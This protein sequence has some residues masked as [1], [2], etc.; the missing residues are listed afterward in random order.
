[1]ALFSI[2]HEHNHHI[3]D[4][5]QVQFMWSRLMAK[6]DALNASQAALKLSLDALKTAVDALKAKAVDGDP[7]APVDAL[8]AASDEMKAQADALTDEV[9]VILNPP[10]PPAA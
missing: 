5:E 7:Q 1:M 10:A 6:L 9:N 3:G 4:S 2:N 8:T